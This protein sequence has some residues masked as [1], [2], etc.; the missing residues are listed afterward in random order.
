MDCNDE[1]KNKCKKFDR[2][3]NDLEKLIKKLG[4]EQKI[5]TNVI[6][7]SDKKTYDF[8]SNK[9][10]VYQ[11]PAFVLSTGSDKYFLYDGK[12]KESD[13]LRFVIEITNKH[14]T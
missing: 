6:S 14:R 3:W 5:L 13:I 10:N 7:E 12:I 11:K 9:M 8:L 1:E 4:Y 2:E